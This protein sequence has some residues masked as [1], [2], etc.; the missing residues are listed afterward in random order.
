MRVKRL[1]I[2]TAFVFLIKGITGAAGSNDV[3][4]KHEEWFVDLYK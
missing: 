2:L 1:L 4:G 3:K